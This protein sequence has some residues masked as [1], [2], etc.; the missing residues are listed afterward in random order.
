MPDEWSP[1]RNRDALSQWRNEQSRSILMEQPPLF[2]RRVSTPL[3]G[4]PN[5]QHIGFRCIT[6]DGGFYYCKP[7]AGQSPIRATEWIC[8]S[9]A[10]HLGIAVAAHAIIEDAN[11]ETFFGSRSPASVA[12]DAEVARM[13]STPAAGELG[14]PLPWLGQHLARLRAFDLFVDNPDRSVRNFILDRDGGF[15]RLCAIDFASSRLLKHPVDR[16][17]IASEPTI[18]VGDIW[19]RTHGSFEESA[20]EMVDRI[21]AV[22]TSA[23]E[24]VL[25]DLPEEWLAQDQRGMLYEYWSGN[26]LK[27]RLELLRARLSDG[28]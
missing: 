28:K 22:P 16:F 26:K 2:N 4:Q 7:D 13:L 20:M 27:N 5:G 24:S 21:R 6:D 8:T 3:P 9:L 25:K 15:N 14:Q 18:F 10:E 11:G 19:Q 12:D 1:P 23:I 17:P